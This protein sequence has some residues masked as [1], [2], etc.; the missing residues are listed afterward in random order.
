[1]VFEKGKFYIEADAGAYK[2]LDRPLDQA[3]CLLR[4]SGQLVEA[5]KIYEDLK[6]YETAAEMWSGVGDH[7]AAMLAYEKACRTAIERHD[8]LKAVNILDTHMVDPARA[9]QLLWSQWPRGH[10]VF[11]CTKLAFNRLADQNRV[12]D[13]HRH[14][15]ELI[16]ATERGEQTLL[17]KLSCELS[18]SFPDR[19]F[20]SRAEDQCRL[21]AVDRLTLLTST[22]FQ[23]SMHIL[24]GLHPDDQML[25][26]DIRRFKREQPSRELQLQPDTTDPRQRGK[27]RELTS[28]RLADGQYYAAMMIGQHLFTM[29]KS[30]SS[31]Q[32]SRYVQL[33]NES[34]TAIHGRIHLDLWDL[35]QPPCCHFARGSDPV[36]IYAGYGKL[37]PESQ[38]LTSPLG[39]DDFWIVHTVSSSDGVLAGLTSDGS[40]WWWDDIQFKLT[41]KRNGL[42][43]LISLTEW[44]RSQIPEIVH[45][46]VTTQPS[47]LLWFWAIAVL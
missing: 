3:R 43:Q 2:K 30:R 16:V 21:S 13:A 19:V 5:A 38:L 45:D 46:A 32:L 37:Q 23:Q 8:I 36:Y 42:P 22:E 11:E 44:I 29:S 14:F 35:Q 31:I 27:L 39:G 6:H 12:A 26:R 41:L 47:N 17:A 34:L 18:M 25:Q 28:V 4:G 20:R 24:G 7:A 9:E 33:A 10:Q 40:Q 15:D 1:M